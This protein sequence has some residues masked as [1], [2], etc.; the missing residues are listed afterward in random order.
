MFSK[1]CINTL[2]LHLHEDKLGLGGAK[3]RP[4]IPEENLIPWAG[5]CLSTEAGKDVIW[6]QRGLAEP[7]Q[8]ICVTRAISYD[9]VSGYRHWQ[10]LCSFFPRYNVYRLSW[11]VCGGKKCKRWQGKFFGS[12]ASTRIKVQKRR[13]TAIKLS[14]FRLGFGSKAKKIVRTP[15]NPA[16]HYIHQF[17]WNAD[18]IL[19][20]KHTQVYSELNITQLAFKAG[21]NTIPQ[22]TFP[23][24]FKYL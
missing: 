10:G 21:V 3:G 11:E 6:W 9:S 12:S 5:G 4:W 7:Y 19:C 15:Y 17:R 24:Y 8:D 2:T 18:Q 1:V 23:Q 20:Q 13:N 22:T 14:K 16:S